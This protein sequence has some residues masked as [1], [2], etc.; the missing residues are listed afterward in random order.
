MIHAIF[1]NGGPWERDGMECR[2]VK[3]RVG[4]AGKKPIGPV[5][6]GEIAQHVAECPS[7]AGDP[8]IAEFLSAPDEPAATSAP[9]VAE[10][11]LSRWEAFVRTLRQRTIGAMVFAALA[12]LLFAIAAATAL[13]QALRDDGPVLAIR[14]V[15]EADPDARPSV[16]IL[17]AVL[18]LAER[19]MDADI[20]DDEA[21]EELSREIRESGALDMFRKLREADG[22][23]RA[24]LVALEACMLRLA[25]AGA[26]AREWRIARNLMARMRLVEA[27]REAGGPGS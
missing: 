7:C 1:G 17:V 27:L 16:H 13:P 24:R 18:A 22:T 6:R 19:A 4:R 15:D 8:R 14:E 11:P 12:A 25:A 3:L 10:R 9:A 2:Q 5:L 23:N 20:G 26:D 21:L